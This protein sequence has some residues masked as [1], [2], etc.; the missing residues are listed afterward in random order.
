MLQDA[1]HIDPT[2]FFIISPL[3]QKLTHKP[4]PIANIIPLSPGGGNKGS[5]TAMAA[6]KTSRQRR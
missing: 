3:T 2:L 5:S 4:W 1:L 6:T